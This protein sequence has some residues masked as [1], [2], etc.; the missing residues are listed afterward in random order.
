MI[1][2]KKILL[3]RDSR[4]LKTFFQVFIVLV[5][6]LVILILSNNLVNNFKRLGLNFGLFFLIDSDRTASFSISDSLIPYNSTDSYGR[7]VLVGLLN[8]LRVMISGIVLAFIVGITVGLGRLSDNWLV[9]KM[10]SIYVETVRNT[11][12]L[13][14]LFFWYFAVFLKFPK[15]YEPGNFY[16]LIFFSNQGIYL[17]RPLGNLQTFLFLGFIIFNSFLAG[18][19]WRKRNQMIV[20]LK[21]KER[22]YQGLMLGILIFVSLIF[23]FG[24]DWQLPQYN[25]DINLIQGG[26]NLSP[27]FATLLLG[28]TIYTAAFIAEIV[29]AGIQSVSKGQWEA[30]KA[31]GLNPS[32][33]M[34]LV[35][36]PQALRVMIPPLTSEF[37]NLAKNSSLAVAIGYNDIYAVA[38]TVSNQTGKAVEML[39]IVMITY[40]VFNLIISTAMNQLNAI[41]RLKE[42]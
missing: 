40:L 17:P 27:E 34:R 3:W 7:A 39:L 4:F 16:N 13:L 23:I 12:L 15:I 26:L 31:L 42:R 19:V 36:F 1:D 24:I 41:V 2:K 14:Q 21:K 11:P 33:V 30:A 22:P 9:R 20:Q 6:G 25:S 10:A 35:I 37:L 8:S 28:L 5:L 29:R 18:L 32:L 38:N